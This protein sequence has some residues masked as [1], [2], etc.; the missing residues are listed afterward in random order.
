MKGKKLS[1]HDAFD[2][3]FGGLMTGFGGM[4][5]ETEEQ[6]KA[7]RPFNKEMSNC[8]VDTA[9]APDTGFWETG[10]QSETIN[11]GQWV[12]VDQYPQKKAAEVGH[13]KWIKYMKTKPKTLY[14]VFLDEELE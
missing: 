3:G 8:V 4:L 9:F 10:I 5:G 11:D 6:N 2:L 14:D 7:R 1:G 13:K 12:I